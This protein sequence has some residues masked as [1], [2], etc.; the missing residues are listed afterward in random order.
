MGAS[1][2]SLIPFV[3]NTVDE[4]VNAGTAANI[5]VVPTENDRLLKTAST[6]A[7]TT[8][9]TPQLAVPLALARRSL[10]AVPTPP[11][12]LMFDPNDPRS[13]QNNR[14]PLSQLKKR[15]LADF[16]SSPAR[17]M[18]SVTASSSSSSKELLV[19]AVEQ[20]HA[21]SSSSS[22][23]TWEIFLSQQMIDDLNRGKQSQLK[24]SPRIA[25]RAVRRVGTTGSPSK[26]VAAVVA[27]D[28]NSVLASPARKR[29]MLNTAKVA[30]SSPLGTHSPSKM[31]LRAE[32]KALSIGDLDHDEM[33]QIM[34]ATGAGSASMGG[35]PFKF[36]NRTA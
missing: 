21:S 33:W 29:A 32:A 30:G 18:M 22:T 16:A 1:T 2:S 6:A 10:R 14:T 12:K 26:F 7:T 3:G 19:A 35:S 24:S 13:P 25:R 20:Q 17:P 5:V 8:Q 36:N 11:E 28:S 4:N 31:M 34:G 27:G 15:K 23:A 9:P